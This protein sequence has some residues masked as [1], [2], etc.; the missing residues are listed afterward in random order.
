AGLLE[1][2]SPGRGFT[3]MDAKVGEWVITPRAGRPVEIN[4]L[5][6]NAVRIVAALSEQV[7]HASR[8]RELNQLADTIA[9]SFN[10][11]FWNAQ[12]NCCY[13][14]VAEN[15]ADASIRPNQLLAI[16]LPFAVLSADR[17]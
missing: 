13:D 8:G 7:G 11:T 17:H 12:E 3:W 1:C 9:T 6:Y 14:V 4:A 16:S 2:C 10:E 15:F 5:W